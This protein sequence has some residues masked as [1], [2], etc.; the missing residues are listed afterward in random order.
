MTNVLIVLHSQFLST[1]RLF[2]LYERAFNSNNVDNR[3]RPAASSGYNFVWPLF[4]SIA[5]S[6]VGV[7]IQCIWPQ[8]KQC[9][10]TIARRLSIFYVLFVL[11]ISYSYLFIMFGYSMLMQFD[12]NNSSHLM[13]NLQTISVSQSFLICESKS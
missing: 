5:L 11:V 7:F 4:V 3:F 10:T 6:L 9:A 1:E 12:Y 2:Y 13:A 8:A